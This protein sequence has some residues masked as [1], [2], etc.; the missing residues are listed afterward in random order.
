MPAFAYPPPWRWYTIEVT[1]RMDG[2]RMQFEV[3]GTARVQARSESEAMQRLRR[4]FPR[5][6]FRLTLK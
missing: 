2:D 6:H 3:T 5:A 1:Q 4:E